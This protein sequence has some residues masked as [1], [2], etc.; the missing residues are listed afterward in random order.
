MRKGQ[1]KFIEQMKTKNFYFILGIIFV[2]IGT[3]WM[4]SYP[5]PTFQNIVTQTHKGIKNLPGNINKLK[6]R[7]EI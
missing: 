7:F 6:V 2:T 4:L 5:S 1:S 3:L